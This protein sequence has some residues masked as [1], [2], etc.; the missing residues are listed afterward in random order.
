MKSSD[1]AII[2]MMVNHCKGYG[3]SHIVFSPG[4]RNAPFA[5]AFDNDSFFETHIIHDERVAGFYAI[6][7]AQTI[8]KPVAL[9]CTSGSAIVNYYPAITEAFFRK[10]PLLVLSADRPKHLINKG[11]GQTIMQDGIF[12]KHVNH[13]VSF[14]DVKREDVKKLKYPETSQKYL[15]SLFAE[16]K[17]PIHYNVHLNE[18]LYET[19]GLSETYPVPSNEDLQSKHFEVDHDFLL[20]LES[21]KIIVLCGQNSAAPGL[22]TAIK[23]FNDNTNVL[24][25]NENTS[26]LYDEKFINCIDRTLNSISAEKEQEFRPDVLI[27][28]GDAIVSKKIKTFFI[29]NQPEF[30]LAIN[31]SEIGIDTYECLDL[32]LKIDSTT[33]FKAINN[34]ELKRN[35]I[36][37]ESKWKMID[38]N[39]KDRL[40]HFFETEKSKTDI[41]VFNAI[42]HCL[43]ENTVLHM[44][45]SSIVRY[46]QL[47]DPVKSINYQSNR[48]TSGIDGSMSTAVGSA[49]ASPDKNHLFITGDISFIYDSNAMWISP[50]PKNLKIIIIDNQGGGIFRIIDGS[51]S[52][53]QLKTFFEA[54]HNTNTK[55]IAEGFGFSVIEENNLNKFETTINDFIQDMNHQF[56]IFRTDTYENPLALKRF[57]NF[58]NNA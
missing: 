16:A 24:V 4:S 51:S 42:N 3:I 34:S 50:F 15:S 56:L 48:G 12:G 19:C 43:L 18:P 54:Q 25:L 53:N 35:T 57:F 22:N 21:K 33:V 52:S 44:A 1:K 30:H 37:F 36:N 6:G 9:C 55:K 27:T 26:G 5:I 31:H 29:N 28:I 47:F 10:I 58:I 11:H 14:E 7:I 17:T 40:P 49:M 38:L 32:Q 2:Q 39:A 23:N 8:D 13:A 46:M 20:K 41:Q 45:N